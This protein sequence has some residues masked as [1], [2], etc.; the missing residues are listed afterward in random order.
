MFYVKLQILIVHDVVR[1]V[2]QIRSELFRRSL[3]PTYKISG[4]GT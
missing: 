3:A 2:V 4:K 1:L